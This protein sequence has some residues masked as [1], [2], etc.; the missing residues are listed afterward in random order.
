MPLLVA[1]DAMVLSSNVTA[2]MLVVTAGKIR[3]KE[4]KQAV[5]Q[6]REVNANVI[7]IVLNRVKASKS[8]YYYPYYDYYARSDGSSEEEE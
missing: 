8:S 5:A 6:L 7:G 2:V 4:L 3:Q 1:S